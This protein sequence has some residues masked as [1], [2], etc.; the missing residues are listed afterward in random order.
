MSSVSRERI[1][2]ILYGWRA[3]EMLWSRVRTVGGVWWHGGR[4]V[5]AR[6]DRVAC[7]GGVVRVEGEV[8]GTCVCASV[9]R[10]RVLWWWRARTD[11]GGRAGMCAFARVEVEASMEDIGGARVHA[12]TGARGGGAHGRERV[13]GGGG[14]G[15]GRGRVACGGG[16]RAGAGGGHALKT[17]SGRLWG[18]ARPSRCGNVSIGGDRRPTR[19]RRVPR[20]GIS[21]T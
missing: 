2:I 9:W 6:G 20:L 12:H 14:G 3:R 11:G 7:C 8:S 4:R 5:V 16:S 13:E 10:R 1:K 15:G 18:S 19:L 21:L 17:R